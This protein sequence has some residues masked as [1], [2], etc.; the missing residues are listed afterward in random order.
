MGKMNYI[1]GNRERR[2]SLTRSWQRLSQIGDITLSFLFL[3]LKWTCRG[4]PLCLLGGGVG[5]L[6]IRSWV[7]GNESHEN[8]NGVLLFYICVW[9]REN[10]ISFNERKVTFMKHV[11]KQKLNRKDRFILALA[12]IVRVLIT[13][14]FIWYRLYLW[15]WDGTMFNKK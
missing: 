7:L 15:V 1:M 6:L 13:P 11:K 4:Y 5:L 9:K 10:F 2:G 14:I 3:F 8:R 12:T